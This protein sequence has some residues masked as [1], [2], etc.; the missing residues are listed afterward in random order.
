MM[1]AVLTDQQRADWE[2]DGFLMVPN[3]LP[4]EMLDRLVCAADRLSEEGVA[5]EG[6]STRHHWQMR[7][8]IGAD[9]AFLDLLDWPATFPLVVDLLNWDIH[10]LTSHLIVRP[11]N[12]PDTNADFKGEGWHRDG[13]LAPQEM[14]EP[15]PRLF[16]KIAY[17]L[18]DQSEPGRGNTQVVPGSHRLIG[19]PAQ[20]PDAPHPYG[21]IEIL[22]KPGDAFLFEQRTW[23]AVGPNLSNLTRKSLFMGYGY[24]WVRAMD[25][26]TPNPD[27]LARCEP[28]RRQLLGE[29][30]TPM[31][32][33]LP[34][35]EDVPLRA[36]QNRRQEN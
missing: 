28:I 8:C 36:W 2:R 23:H 7:N 18:S 21:A 33:Y 9:P 25:Y 14:Q 12:P 16:L 1:P 35:D 26:L 30:R 27:L 10:L 22:G 31:G 6:L 13:G 15:H 4:P 3:A 5:R 32:I 19:P 11:P 34:Q 29:V 20:A 17:L 24:R